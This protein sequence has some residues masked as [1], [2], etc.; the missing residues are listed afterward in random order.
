MICGMVLRNHLRLLSII[1]FGLGGLAVTIVAVRAEVAP[2]GFA[3]R[4]TWKQWRKITFPRTPETKYI[5]EEETQTVC[6]LAEASASAMA[7]EFPGTLEEYP[8]LSWEW[9]IEGVLEAGNAEK[10]EGDDYAARIYV[11]FERDNRLTWWEEA[12]ASLFESFYGQEI[13]GQTLAFIWANHM[14]KGEI[15]SSPYTKHARMVILQ[16]GN[17]RAGEWVQQEANIL[18]WYHRA[19]GTT[20]QPPPV[21]SIAIMTDSDNTGET[22][23]ACFRNV[24]LKR[25]GSYE[26]VPLHDTP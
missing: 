22:A 18:H 17:D 5:F 3:D 16:N 14:K 12:R 7:I 2:L 19:F 26:R 25:D 13:P 20:E 8:L 4:Q 11:N 6:T 23:R 10:K 24:V 21:H 9:Q 1:L 15:I